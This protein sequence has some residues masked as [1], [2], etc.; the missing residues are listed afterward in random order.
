[1]EMMTKTLL[2]AEELYA[3]PDHGGRTELVKGELIEM[4]PAGA[5]HGKLAMRLGRFVGNFVADHDLGEVY[6]AETGFTIA[7]NPDTVRAPDVTFVAKERI[8]MEGEPR[9][10]WVIAPDLVAEIISPSDRASD[11]QDKVTDYLT[12]GVRLVWLV[13]PQARTV[14]VYQS[15]HR[16]Q[17]LLA[18]ET[19][20][21]EDVLPGFE[22]PLS[23]LFQ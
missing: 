18:E 9:G 17:I 6:A 13:D 10:F 22:L 1:M 8:P 19:L 20:T 4:S 14:T 3:K 7:Q 16:I 12:A 15:L 11:V 2:T 21:G 5:E 23:Q